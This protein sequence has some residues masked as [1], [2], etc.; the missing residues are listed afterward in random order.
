LS[1]SILWLKN[2][3]GVKQSEEDVQKVP[4][5]LTELGIHITCKTIQV[6]TVLGSIIGPLSA[7]LR[8]KCPKTGLIRGGTYGAAIGAVAGPVVTLATTRGKTEPEIYDRC[9]RLRHNKGQLWVDRSFVLAAFFG[10]LAAGSVGMV[11]GINGA[12]IVTPLGRAAW[13]KMTGTETPAPTPAK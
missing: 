7:L 5:A 10:F 11:A 3:A 13:N 12:V 8:R 4:N 1:M 6:G 9:Y 2:F